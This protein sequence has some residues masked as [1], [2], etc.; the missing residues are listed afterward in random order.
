VRRLLLFALIAALSAGCARF[1]REPE[2]AA[3]AGPLLTR[4]EITALLDEARRTRAKGDFPLARASVRQALGAAQRSQWNDLVADADFLLGEIFV[5]EGLPRQAVDAFARTYDLSRRAGDRARGVRSLNAL[6]NVLLDV[7]DYDRA[8]EASA[9]ALRLARSLGDLRAQTTALNNVGETHRFSG[10]DQAAMDA[11][12]EALVLARQAGTARD[13]AAILENMASTARRRGQMEAAA[14]YFTEAL[15]AARQTGNPENVA[16]LLNALTAVRLAQHRPQ[17]A[18][19]LARDAAEFARRQSLHRPLVTAVQNQGLAAWGMGDRETARRSL[20]EAVQ[21][22]SA[23]DDRPLLAYAQW[24]LGHLALESGDQPGAA[25][26]LDQALKLFRG[27]HLDDE[28][29]KVE[30]ELRALQE[31]RP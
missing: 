6:A 23:M 7:G 15:A 8:F 25:Q 26:A 2:P 29:H 24:H 12:T 14:G 31:N 16:N 3:P 9:Q 13:Q 1:A 21:L 27:L 10:R 17:D 5:Q 18:L 28:A 11:Y 4:D 20:T 30:S 19:A 22:A